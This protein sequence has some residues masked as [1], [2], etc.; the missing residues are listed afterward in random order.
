MKPQ[1]K[2]HTIGYSNEIVS[3]IRPIPLLEIVSLIF[4]S[5][6]DVKVIIETDYQ[7]KCLNR[8]ESSRLQHMH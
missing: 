6:L 5:I 3:S 2:S 1:S 7:E 8:E 4:V